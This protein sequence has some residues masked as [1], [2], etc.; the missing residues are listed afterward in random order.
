ML[1]NLN[2]IPSAR[3]TTF[4]SLST[5]AAFLVS[6]SSAQP[7]AVTYPPG[8]VEATFPDSQECIAKN[9]YLGPQ[10][11]D[12]CAPVGPYP[13]AG[14]QVYIQDATNFCIMLP[15]PDSDYLKRMVYGGGLQPTILQGVGYGRAFCMG[16]YRT[17]GKCIH[18]STIPPILPKP[19]DAYS[20]LNE[21][22]GA[23]PLPAGGVRSAH[24]IKGASK[25]G[26]K[27]I[28]I[29]GVFDCEA[30]GVNCTASAP[31]TYDDGGQYDNVPFIN[32]GKEPYSGVDASRHPAW[33][34]Y[35]E[36][37]GNGTFLISLSI[38]NMQIIRFRNL[39]YA[40]L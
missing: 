12:R 39:L 8:C 6:L 3:S 38:I 27:Y 30:L 18:I 9:W 31:G 2:A 37:A 14:M 26:K 5:A 29:S 33:P 35:V 4:L 11:R 32:C 22:V 40:N 25:S 16:S 13:I 1:I 28:Q 20:N 24:V 17:P 34:D 23:L 19:T 10:A 15:D 7:P 21:Y 36:Q